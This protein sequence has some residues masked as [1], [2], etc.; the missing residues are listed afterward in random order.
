MRQFFK[1]IDFLFFERV[2]PI[3]IYKKIRR[4][5]LTRACPSSSRGAWKRRSTS[6][7]GG[8]KHQRSRRESAILYS[9]IYDII[10][11]KREVC[12]LFTPCFEAS[13][14]SL[15]SINRSIRCSSSKMKFW[16]LLAASRQFINSSVKFTF[17]QRHLSSRI[18]REHVFMHILRTKHLWFYTSYI[19]ILQQ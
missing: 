8:H 4:L 3:Y 13:I 10:T 5:T 14:T 17:C 12:C 16:G 18:S 1:K 6:R 11:P 9:L 15:K 19:K 7:S 2:F